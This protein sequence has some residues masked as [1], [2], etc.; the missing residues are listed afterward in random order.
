MGF[1]W[2]LEFE[3]KIN[4][5]LGQFVPVIMGLFEYPRSALIDTRVIGKLIGHLQCDMTETEWQFLHHYR[6]LCHFF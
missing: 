4:W 1:Y 6:P 5:D 2:D 3:Q